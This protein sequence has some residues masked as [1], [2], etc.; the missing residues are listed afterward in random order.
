MASRQFACELKDG[1]FV[2]P[3]N[4]LYHPCQDLLLRLRDD[5]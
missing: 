4:R 5:S 3:V 2:A 1:V